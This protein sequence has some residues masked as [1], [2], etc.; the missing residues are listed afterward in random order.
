M[1]DLTPSY[2]IFE[3]VNETVVQLFVGWHQEGRGGS[4]LDIGCGRGLLGR[5]VAALGFNVTGV[6]S[7]PAA[8]DLAA[9][10]LGAVF[11]FDLTNF[12]EVA[13]T[14]GAQRFD[15]ILFADVLEHVPDPL[16]V[17]KFYRQF[18]R[19]GGQVV[20]SLPNIGVW[21]RR[22]ALLF[23]HFDYADSGVM[24]R[25]HLR[26]FTFQTAALLV[27]EAGMKTL[28]VGGDP[29]IVRAFLF[30]IKPFFAPRTPEAGTDPGA[31]INSASYRLYR[32]WVLP[33]ERAICRLRRPLLCFRVVLVAAPDSP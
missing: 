26:F 5:E 13:A 28:T 16:S 1:F 21:D 24:D 30:L 8:R 7:N 11:A 19:D 20:I 12:A 25:T 15:F 27:Q 31:I 10:R 3:D 18:L 6:E 33:A 22:L 23:G 14:L 32:K 17:L 29:G 2:Y 9:T 4:V